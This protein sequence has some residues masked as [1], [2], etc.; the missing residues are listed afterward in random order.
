MCCSCRG[1]IPRRACLL[2]LLPF[3]RR[4]HLARHHP[5]RLHR[6]LCPHHQFLRY[7][8]RFLQYHHR[9]LCRHHPYRRHLSHRLHLGRRHPFPHLR[10]HRRLAAEIGRAHV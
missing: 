9:R 8:H 4:S 3:R 10:Y 7:H 2:F 6:R 1:H 5:F